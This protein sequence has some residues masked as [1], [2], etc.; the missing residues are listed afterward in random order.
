MLEKD[1][2][3]FL[4]KFPDAENFLMAAELRQE[5]F[6]LFRQRLNRIRFNPYEEKRIKELFEYPACQ[7]KW[8]IEHLQTNNKNKL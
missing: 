4:E 6:T 7:E 2:K 1:K 3:E 8:F 5:C